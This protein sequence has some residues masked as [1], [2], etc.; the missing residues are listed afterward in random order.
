VITSA[1]AKPKLARLKIFFDDILHFSF[2]MN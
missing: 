2:C 1:A